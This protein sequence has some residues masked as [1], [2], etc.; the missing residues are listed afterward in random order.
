MRGKH[1]AQWWYPSISNPY[2]GVAWRGPNVQTGDI[3]VYWTAIN[4]PAPDKKI[5]SLIFTPNLNNGLYILIGL[6]LS[7]QPHYVKPSVE[8]SGGPD[9]WAAGTAMYAL[10]HG[11]AGM[12]DKDVAFKSPLIAPRWTTTTAGKVAATACYPASGGYVAYQ[13]EY[14]PAERKMTFEITGNAPSMD[15]H[16]LLPMTMNNV[17]KVISNGQ[18]VTY[19]CS[20]IESSRYVDFTSAIKGV[21]HIEI[22]LE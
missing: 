2:S 1:I 19:A 11:L 17:K 12:Q 20:S 15:F 8:S 7:D 22:Y 3:G 13:Y 14:L 18:T 10:L 9:N 21:Q 6:T 4:N 16:I 5:K